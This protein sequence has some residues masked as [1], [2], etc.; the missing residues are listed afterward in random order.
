MS[1]DEKKYDRNWYQNISGKK[2]RIKEYVKKWKQWA[3]KRKKKTVFS[4]NAAKWGKNADQN[5]SEYGHFL[6]SENDELKNVEVD[7]VTSFIKD[8]VK[9]FSDAQ[10]YTDDDGNSK[11][12]G[13]RTGF[14]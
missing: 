11:K 1:E 12:I 7:V 2:Q 5:N 8:K 6:R 4:P 3:K 14:W 10:V 13:L 9:T